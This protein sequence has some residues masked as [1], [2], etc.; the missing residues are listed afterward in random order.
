MSSSAP[1]IKKRELPA[2]VLSLVLHLAFLLPLAWIHLSS[3][4]PELKVAIESL[5]EEER[6]AEEF[7]RELSAD[8]QVAETLNVVAS[9]AGA[10]AAMGGGGG[11]GGGSLGAGVS[12]QKIEQSSQFKTPQVSINVGAIGLPGIEQLGN[13]LGET[14]VT[15]EVGAV[16]EGYAPALSRITQEVLRMMREDRVLAVWMFDESESMKD[17]QA[18]IRE[19]FHKVYEELGIVTEKDTK[20]RNN[21]DTLLTAVHSF[22]KSL[23]TLTP[24]PTAS[25][26]EVRAAIDKIGVDESGLENT[27]QSLSAVLDKYTSFV[28]QG[29][30]KMVVIIVT[31]E[32]GDDGQYI[33]ET[34]EKAKRLR[35]PV[36]IL[37]RESVFGFPIARIRWKDPKYGLDHWL[38][39][40]RGPES[41]LIEALQFD[42]FHERWDTHPSGFGPYE[43]A[44]LAKETGGIFFVLPGE[45]EN[46]VGQA[47]I[48]KRKF[49][50]LDLKQYEPELIPRREY[51]QIRASSK[52]RTTIADVVKLLNPYL[53]KELRIKF[54]HYPPDKPGFE[55]DGQVQF[56]RAL[57]TMSLLNQAVQALEKVKPL[58]EK[59][60]SQR[61]RANYDLILAQTMA[62]RVRLFQF[63]LAMDKHGKE[64]PKF[65]DPKS[66]EWNVA[67]VK[68]VLAPDA[69]QIKITKVDF[70]EVKKQEQAA[71]DQF[72]FVIQTHPRTP[73]SNRAEYELS[74][75]FGIRFVEGFRDPKYNGLTGIKFPTL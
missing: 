70:D 26:P 6:P 18:M 36:Y 16:V 44:R 69:Q 13:D 61:W 46:L 54:W 8:T 33:D 49:A 23:N 55:K 20:L 10:M 29:R 7:T 74:Q 27:L 21:Q 34:I 5:I 71:R 40:K 4:V 22:G 15:G 39:I 52:F 63:L 73:W 35:V 2:F 64:F 30:R 66:N 42:G 31:D 59:E 48:D 28:R 75:G 62:Q 57:R 3:Q 25:I 58:R 47:A 53:D 51:E 60:E 65:K 41:A 56:N 17:D 1:L 68:Q 9:P 24:K 72:N 12:A 19:Q 14:Q 67:R 38:E 43:Q 11:G 50:F 45:E 32:S 37:G